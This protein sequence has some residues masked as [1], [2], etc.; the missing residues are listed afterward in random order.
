MELPSEDEYL[1]IKAL[2]Y[3]DLPTC[4][5][6]RSAN[7][8]TINN[9]TNID[10]HLRALKL[11]KGPEEYE[12]KI[13]FGG[14]FRYT[15]G[16]PTDIANSLKGLVDAID[17]YAHEGMFISRYQNVDSVKSHKLA[18]LNF[19]SR[20]RVFYHQCVSKLV[21]F[22]AVR[23]LKEVKRLQ[24]REQLCQLKDLSSSLYGQMLEIDIIQQLREGARFTYRRLGQKDQG[25]KGLFRPSNVNFF[26]C[27][28]YPPIQIW[29]EDINHTSMLGSTGISGDIL[30]FPADKSCF[31]V[32]SILL[33]K[34]K[35]QIVVNFIQVTIQNNHGVSPGG[36]FAM[37]MLVK[38]IRIIN[39][40]CHVLV[41][42]YFVVPED[43]YVTFSSS[44]A[45]YLRYLF[46]DITIFVMKIDEEEIFPVNGNG[47]NKKN[48]K[49]QMSI[50][51]S[52]T[53]STPFRGE[54]VMNNGNV[55]QEEEKYPKENK[56]SQSDMSIEVN[57]TPTLF[58]GEAVMNV[59]SVVIVVDDKE[60]KEKEGENP[61]KSKQSQQQTSTGRNEPKKREKRTTI[62]GNEEE[63]E[64]K[65]E[66]LKKSTS[67]KRN[68]RRKKKIETA[69][70]ENEEVKEEKKENEKKSFF[71][72]VL[73]LNMTSSSSLPIPDVLLNSALRKQNLSLQ[74]NRN[75]NLNVSSPRLLVTISNFKD[76]HVTLRFRPNITCVMDNSVIRVE[77]SLD[78]ENDNEESDLSEHSD[79]SEVFE[80][81]EYPRS[82]SPI[83]SVK[84]EEKNKRRVYPTRERHRPSTLQ[85]LSKETTL[86]YQYVSKGLYFS[87]INSIFYGY[88][89][90][91]TLFY[92][93]SVESQGDKWRSK[94]ESILNL[95]PQI[96]TTIKDCTD[97]FEIGFFKIFAENEIL[98]LL[99]CLNLRLV[100][101]NVR[102]LNEDFMVK[103]K[104]YPNISQDQIFFLLRIQDF[105]SRVGI[106]T[107]LSSLKK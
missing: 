82:V 28:S 5:C 84:E 58:R 52:G 100:N 44:E 43:K 46:S 12:R 32:D 92:R 6:E 93:R 57:R 36:F 76:V 9:Y 90:I 86:N 67:T 88:L 4:L 107:N 15:L 35:G 10:S 103:L 64:K 101:V 60:D 83:C 66:N 38:L 105:L 18:Q 54:A 14:Q 81:S 51:T 104:F 53:S 97:V 55:A 74:L 48:G 65:G 34:E 7:T 8:N 33:V 87:Q 72:E 22:S 26:S 31:T 13:L 47:T 42:F 95:L 25:F 89:K 49:S 70:K 50:E 29:Y 17:E 3:K 21:F 16:T 63:K 11:P 80:E 96:K 41:N 20:R 91:C 68:Q 59:G 45:E 94:D 78:T 85:D 71:D 99:G 39:V 106:Y 102:I 75:R 23:K 37:F 61:K 77:S 24:M 19:S 30:Y 62:E 79:H 40:E 2:L 27:V 1:K 69:T 73:D 56:Q 98:L